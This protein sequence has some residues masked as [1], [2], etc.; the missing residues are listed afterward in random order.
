LSVALGDVGR[1]DIAQRAVTAA[2]ADAAFVKIGFAGCQRAATVGVQVA[3]ESVGSAALVLV[4]YADHES[5]GAPSPESLLSSARDMKAAGILLDTYDK[6]GAGLTTLL[7]PRA[8]ADFVRMAKSG[9]QFV[10][11]AGKLTATDI[12]NLLDTG[13]DIIGVR[14]A[15]CDGGRNGVVTT[16]RVRAIRNYMVSHAGLGVPAS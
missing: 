13:A 8:I 4:A 10:A 14:G 9:G 12:G 16:A 11:L 5:A 1:D 3:I 6:G 7:T 15:A 2:A